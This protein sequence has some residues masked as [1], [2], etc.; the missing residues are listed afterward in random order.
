MVPISVYIVLIV[1]CLFLIAI[2]ALPA[3]FLYLPRSLFLEW[4]FCPMTVHFTLLMILQIVNL[5]IY[6]LI[7]IIILVLNDPIKNFICL[8]FV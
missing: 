3:S 7:L 4:S 2:Q 1:Q 6:S 8:V 5:M